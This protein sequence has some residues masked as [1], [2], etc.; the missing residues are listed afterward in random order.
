[1]VKERRAGRERDV[2]GAGP[3]KLPVRE[4]AR[5]L[6]SLREEAAVEFRV[7]ARRN[8]S[9][10]PTVKLGSDAELARSETQL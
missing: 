1:M 4:A 3:G 9:K 6:K 7:A 8:S 10:F 5:A 2:L